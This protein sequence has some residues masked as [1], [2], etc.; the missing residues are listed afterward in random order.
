MIT[1]VNLQ[2]VRA[3]FELTL[4]VITH[5]NA[6]DHS[7]IE[8]VLACRKAPEPSTIREMC[9]AVRGKPDAEILDHAL[10]ETGIAARNRAGASG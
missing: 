3:A 2:I 7:L 8:D 6:G 10:I 5:R 9:G 4:G 1:P